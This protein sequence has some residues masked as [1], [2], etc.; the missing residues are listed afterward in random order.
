M[1]M[2]K[3]ELVAA[4]KALSK[5]ELQELVRAIEE[6]FGVSATAPMII[7]VP[8]VAET[9]V[10]EEEQT[11]FTVV[12][13]EIGPRMVNVIRALRMAVDG[14]GLK[15]AK[16]LVESTPTVLLEGVT[17]QVADDLKSDLEMQGAVVRLE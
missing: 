5:D 4:I 9:I 7:A 16:D 2:S 11:E 10:V 12:L 8:S 14:L 13:S 1:T 3:D 6:T 15:D 17:R